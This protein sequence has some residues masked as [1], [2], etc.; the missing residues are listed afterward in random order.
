M[1]RSLQEA[2]IVISD[3][4]LTLRVSGRASVFHSHAAVTLVGRKGQLRQVLSKWNA[5][6][7]SFSSGNDPGGFTRT[8]DRHLRPTVSPLI[9][10]WQPWIL[11]A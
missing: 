10:Y 1:V 8:W 9:G 11:P 3:A 2:V 7:G 6:A 4:P 5:Q